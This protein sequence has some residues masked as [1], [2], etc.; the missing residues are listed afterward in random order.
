MKTASGIIGRATRL[1]SL[2]AFL[3]AP[4]AAAWGAT[5][6]NIN[7][8][9]TNYPR[10][11]AEQVKKAIGGKVDAAWIT[12]TAAIRMSRAFN[13]AGAPIPNNNA[14]L[15]TVVGADKLHY[16]YRV[17]EFRKWLT[18]KYGQP[19]LSFKS[20]PYGKAPAQLAGRKG[21]ILFVDA[22]WS[23]ASGHID[24][25]DGQQVVH[26][27]YF[28]LA[29][30]VY[31]WESSP[32]ALAALKGKITAATNVRAGPSTSA[33][34]LGTLPAGTVVNLVGKAPTSNFW[35]IGNGQYVSASY[36]QLLQ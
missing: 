36:V 7:A 29:K 30:Q 3:A 10:G 4:L 11:E 21:I 6:P 25:W 5:V 33:Q 14:N 8:L 1:A 35:Q 28:E 9:I 26:H 18:E 32:P 31:L 16:A 15:A 23:D 17:A 19:T 20:G 13:Y 12:N 22:G 24:L 2:L 27:G 34:I